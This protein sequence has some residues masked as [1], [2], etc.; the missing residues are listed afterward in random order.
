ME[1]P[2]ARRRLLVALTL[3]TKVVR[4]G[5]GVVRRVGS[6][7]PEVLLV[8]RPRYDDWTFPKGKA[9]P[10][11]TDS[12]AALRE[13]EEESGL[14]CVLGRELPAT[15]YRDGRGRR[16]IVRY[17]TMAVVGGSFRPHA[18]VDEIAWATAELAASKLS[19]ERD[20]AV[21]AATPDPL[22]VVRH[23]SAGDRD[24]WEA[25]DRRRPLDERGR[26]QAAELVQRLG[27]YK[28]TRVVSSP[29]DRCV[30]TVAPLAHALG[31]QV[32]L[33]DALRE[34]TDP[35]RVRGFLLELD[36]EAVVCGHG[37]ELDELFGRVR[38]AETVAVDCAKGVLLE[39]GRLHPPG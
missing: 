24:D 12:R 1:A 39:L 19:Y 5:G 21:L 28:I 37:P 18:E 20:L 29:F 11:E 27:G 38:K 4:A 9:E 25:D 26:R 8:H 36:S 17:W 6:T 2:P 16:K 13:V 22:L 10:G 23:A 30:E 3:G 35:E 15:R 34:G 33:S 7:G 31:L 14:R 32:E